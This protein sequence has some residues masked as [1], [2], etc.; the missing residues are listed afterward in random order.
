VTAN[1]TLHP[2]HDVAYFI[3]GQDRGGCAGAMSY[4]TAAGEPP[5]EWAGKGAAALGLA[6]QVDPAVLTRLYQHNIGP[7]GEQLVSRRQPKAAQEREQAA[8]AAYLA[9]HPYASAVELAEV[10][11]AER[12]KDPHQVPYFDLTVSAVKSVSV[13]HASY[14][15]AARQAGDHGD[16]ERAAVLDARADE[17]E[18]AVM[19]A[20]RD[21]VGWLDRHAT[22]TR[23]GH[24]SARTGEWRDGDG[25]VASL[26][27]HHLSRDGDP[28]LHVHAAIWN[29]VQRG[30]GADHKWR[31]LDSRTLHNQRL[32]VAPVADRAL[33]ARLAALGYAMV[34]RPDG[35]GAEIGGVS[36]DVI[37]LFSSRAVAVTG[38]LT[39]LA[40]EYEASYGRPPGRRTLWL[41]HQQA[42]QNTR[43]TKSQARRTVA[44]R[45]GAAEPTAALRLAAWE[46]QTVRRELQA[47]SAVYEQVARF[48]AAHSPDAQ[49]V[50][51]D[52]A[53]RTAARI[54]VA[55]VQ[56]QHAV[57]TMAQLRFE[58]HRALP[59]LGLGADGQ[60]LVDEVAALAVSGRAG[61][62]VVQIAAPDPADVSSLG[63]RASDGGS[64]YRPPHAERYCTL[65]HLDTEEHILAAAKTTVP[66]LVGTGQAQAAVQKSELDAGQREAVVLMLTATTMASVL[67]AP[68]GAGKT[69]SMAEF[70]RL[71]TAHTGRRVIGLTTSTNAARVLQ[72]EGL[73]ESYNI[74]AF[75]GKTEG[76]SEL[77]RPVP[78]HQDDVL[79][80]DEASQLATADL[81][82]IAEAARQAGARVIVTG[83]TAQLGAVEAGGVLRLLAQEVPAVQLHEVRRFDAPWEREASI[84]LRAGDLAA[85]AAYD[86]HGRIRGADQETA[87]DRAATM[88]LADHLR[89]KDVLLLAG[90]NAEAA[91]LSRRVQA[92]L[93]QLG[94]VGPPAAALADGNQA[95]VGD[96]VRARLNTEIDAGGRALTNRDTLK[97]SGF[98]GP[99]AEVRR[100]RPDGSWTGPFRVPRSYLARSAELAYAGNVHVAQGRTVDTAHLLVTGTLSRHAL[101][102]GMTRGRQ[103]NTAHVVTGP[104]APPGH[105][106]CP[107]ATAESLLNDVLQRD[108]DEASATEAIRQAQDWA[109][110]TG[111]LLT[112]WCA[113]VRH[114][115]HPDLDRQIKAR[116]SQSEGWRYDR[117]H[118][119]PVLQHQLRAAQ[120][121]GHDVSEMINRITAA[122][123]DGARSI[124][125][126]LHGRLQRLPLPARA[127]AVPW[128]QRTPRAAPPLA[129][130]L[131][132]ELDQRRRELGQRA[133]ANPEP[134]L[135]RHLG[136][137]PGPQASPVLREDYAQRAGTAAAYREARGITDTH[138]AVSF[139]PHPEP[140]LQAMQQDTFRALEIADEQAEIRAMSRGE[141]EARVLDGD[142]A[143]ATAP[144]DV[145]RQLRQT[146]Q[147]EADAW[148]QSADARARHDQAQADNAST[149]AAEMAAEKT[150]LEAVNARFELWSRGTAATRQTAGQAKAELAR[151]GHEPATRDAPAPQTIAEWWRQFQA[152]ADAVDRAIEREHQAGQLQPPAGQPQPEPGPES[153][154]QLE[155]PRLRPEIFEPEPDR[156]GERVTRLDELQTRA[157]VAAALISA[158]N[159]ERDAR[160]DYA[161]RI[162]RQAQAE[163]EA[164]PQAE[165][166]PDAELEL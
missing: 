93:A 32:A 31:T 146:A 115:L 30:D 99:D 150:R 129:H 125:G 104:T 44:G 136:P 48:A 87:Y 52:A 134:W 50:L 38:E 159:A 166:L 163:A 55:E 88:W 138:Q 53:K 161:A 113:A 26:F 132:A 147:A 22:Y 3:S 5:G 11:A 54:A 112:L 164:A 23:T 128:A 29:R 162:E 102:V 135:T 158:D 64:I 149:L 123:L 42:G 106:P 120:L 109:G 41:L 69:R 108:A 95:G 131:A 140:E 19:E 7:G 97:V 105:P 137:P 66:Q 114:S 27:L 77:R 56:R 18:D 21:A 10:R 72:H 58:V 79:V 36:Q 9:A 85:I 92:R 82:L 145:S 80:L 47:L 91:E 121:A 75:L 20:A 127:D 119:R 152:D 57:W 118:A 122:P 83:D 49:T 61:T 98:F 89:G 63:V 142:R 101:Y 117:E 51:D 15:I 67:I 144:P 43:R 71:W 156:H 68:A 70:A 139:D 90:S 143:Q 16:H 13:L 133:L 76:T 124:S 141:L 60:A 151:R 39:R 153:A 84:Q 1:V 12:G 4:Y 116:L 24:H 110:G 25:L 165:T 86:R 73:A 33:E 100:Q 17:L 160:A 2:G 81:A 107:Q 28:Q 157:A 130:Q 62:G 6:G 34:P 45:T 78:L 111:H 74:A 96:L 37:D 35:N 40:Q 14:R 126:V 46:A 103:A 155:D 154:T 8:V 65:A 94:T 59:V 148:Q